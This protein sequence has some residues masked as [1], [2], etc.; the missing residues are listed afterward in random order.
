MVGEVCERKEV[1]IDDDSECL[2]EDGKFD[3][4]SQNSDVLLICKKRLSR[5]VR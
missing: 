3:L 1:G 5:R 4:V 2:V